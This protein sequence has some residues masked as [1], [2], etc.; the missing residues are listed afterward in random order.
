MEDFVVK[1]WMIIYAREA[2]GLVQYFFLS[3]PLFLWW[4]NTDDAGDF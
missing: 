2:K 3:P 4:N 1:C